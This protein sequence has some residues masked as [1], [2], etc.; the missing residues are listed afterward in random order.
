MRK[1]ELAMPMQMNQIES[2]IEVEDIEVQKRVDILMHARSV[3]VKIREILIR[4]VYGGLILTVAILTAGM[5]LQGTTKTLESL[6]KEQ[7][8]DRIVTIPWREVPQ[9]MR[10]STGSVKSADILREERRYHIDMARESNRTLQTVLSN[11]NR[12]ASLIRR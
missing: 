6:G 2:L 11:A 10:M 7:V 12:I 3:L 8:K 5:I 4:G 9:S 1:T